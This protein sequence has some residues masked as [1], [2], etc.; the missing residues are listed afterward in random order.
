MK[1]DYDVKRPATGTECQVHTEMKC[2]RLEEFHFSRNR[3]VNHVCQAS[4][5]KA[6]T[7]VFAVTFTTCIIIVVGVDFNLLKAAYHLL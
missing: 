1:F 6:T 4:T 3:Q 2:A 7:I 5:S